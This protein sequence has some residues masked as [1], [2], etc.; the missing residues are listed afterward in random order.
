VYLVRLCTAFYGPVWLDV[1]S[2]HLYDLEARECRKDSGTP[3]LPL[4]GLAL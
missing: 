2:A 3:L 1:R 4:V